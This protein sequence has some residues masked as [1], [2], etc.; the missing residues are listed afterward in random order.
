MLLEKDVT[1]QLGS[2]AGIGQSCFSCC[3]S[4]RGFGVGGVGGVVGEAMALPLRR[5]RKR[6]RKGMIAWRE[7]SIFGLAI[8]NDLG[9]RNWKTGKGC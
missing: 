2:G 1:V 3:C 5:Q 9:F 4:C 8:G 6:R 7:G